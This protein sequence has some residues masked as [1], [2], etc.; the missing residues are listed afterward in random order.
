MK[1]IQLVSAFALTL[2]FGCNT[3]PEEVETKIVEKETVKV[4]EVETPAKEVVVVETPA[5]EVVVEEKKGTTIKIGP[6][7]G[8]IETKKVDISINN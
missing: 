7:G 1:I 8:S 3:Q 5:K 2:I 6:D 4:V